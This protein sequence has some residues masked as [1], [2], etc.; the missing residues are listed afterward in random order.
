MIG[1]GDP[2]D[3]TMATVAVDRPAAD[4]VR[5][6]LRGRLT[7]VSLPAVWDAARGP[8]LQHQPRRVEID[9]SDVTYC[10]GAG[11]G[12][13]LELRRATAACGGEVRLHGLS[14]ELGRLVQASTLTD[15]RAEPLAPPP[16][17]G[18]VRRTGRS[19]AMLGRELAASVAFVGEMA[20]ALAVSAVRP[21]R[22]RWRDFLLTCQKVGADALPVVALLGGMIGL[23]M[24]FQ[25]ASVASRYGVMPFIPAAV[26]L[27]IIRELGPL[28]V[29]VIV[30]GRSGSAFAAEIGTMKVTEELDALR[31]FG[32]PPVTFLAVPRVLAV[33]LMVPLL[34]VFV[35]LIGTAAGAVVMVRDGFSS[36]FYWTAVQSA[37]DPTDV[38]G[39]LFKTLVFGLIIGA[40]GCMQGLRTKTG[41]SAV[42]NSTTRA[43][44]SA[45][46]LVI[47]ADMIFGALFNVLGI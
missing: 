12:L 24:A 11:L 36:T 34:T 13:F 4:E 17:E 27:S 42:G 41:P 38:L 20:A 26:S 18:L 35:D 16:R 31:T 23:I 3:N 25:I 43:V 45:I 15:P 39:G 1:M 33:M 46:V 10:D 32:L 2:A 6:V 37:I 30:A 40:V 29:A 22:I 28:I 5:I 8:I 19:A 21:S 47:V 9:A 44:V 14:E 7:A